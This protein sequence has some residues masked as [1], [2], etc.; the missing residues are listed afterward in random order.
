MV[1]C[2][3]FFFCPEKQPENYIPP[4]PPE[5][6][7]EIFQSVQQGINFDKYD[8]IKVFVTGRNAP[9]KGISRYVLSESVEAWTFN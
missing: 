9:Q 3:L 8:E 6:E 2:C 1:E 5:D 7:E 4:P